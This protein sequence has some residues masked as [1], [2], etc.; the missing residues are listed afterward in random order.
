MERSLKQMFRNFV[1]ALVGKTVACKGATMAIIGYLR[2]S[3]KAQGESGLGLEAQRSAVEAYEFAAS[4]MP[5]ANKFMLHV[6]A[7]VAE[8]EAKA[9]SERTKAALTAYKAR[10]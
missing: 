7:A 4:D 10:R 3:T 5:A 8:H 9:I 1:Y 2:V 6:M